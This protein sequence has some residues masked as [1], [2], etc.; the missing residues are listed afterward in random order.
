MDNKRDIL[1]LLLFIYQD[2]VIYHIAPSCQTILGYP[3]E[4]KLAKDGQP[5]YKWH[6]SKGLFSCFPKRLL[7]LLLL[8]ASQIFFAWGIARGAQPDSREISGKGEN[9][10]ASL[11]AWKELESGLE[12]AEFETDADGSSITALRIDPARFEFVLGMRSEDGGE[13]R[14]LAEW[15]KELDLVAAIN[16]SMYL[17]DGKTS[18]GYLRMGDHVNNPRIAKR[19]GAFFVAAP[20]RDGLPE[21][22]IID[23]DAP[24]FP[25]LMEDYNLVAQNYRMINAQRRI[26]WQPGGPLYAISAVGQ[27]GGGRILF[28]HSKTPVEAYAFARRLLELPLDVRTVMYVEGGAQAGLLVRTE[29]LFRDLAPLHAPSLFVTGNLRASLPNVLGVR[30]KSLPSEDN[31]GI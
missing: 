15:A 21:A 22:A 7:L 18:T 23:R 8:T 16:A 26:L 12:Y 19:F 28:L 9:A 3:N 27:D 29:E 30:R 5:S 13:A 6:M 20:K 10:T 17:P 4:A 31:K 24:G 11:S 14:P 1:T 25:G 2:M